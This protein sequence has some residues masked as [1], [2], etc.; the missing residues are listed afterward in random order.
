MDSDI[1]DP[2][3]FAP[4]AFAELDAPYP[5]QSQPSFDYGDPSY[6]STFWPDAE[7]QQ[8]ALPASPVPAP[9]S[10]SSG[11]STFDQQ[12]ALPASPIPAPLPTTS[13]PSTSTSSTVLPTETLYEGYGDPMSCGLPCAKLTDTVNIRGLICGECWYCGAPFSGEDFRAFMNQLAKH[14]KR[15]FKYKKCT[16][17]DR[18]YVFLRFLGFPCLLL[19]VVLSATAP[20]P[21][22]QPT[23]V[24]RSS[25]ALNA[26]LT[27]SGRPTKANLS[28]CTS[29]ASLGTCDQL[30]SLMPR[31]DSHVSLLLL[32]TS[33]PLTRIR[34]LSLGKPVVKLARPKESPKLLE[35]VVVNLRRRST[36][37]GVL[38]ES[39]RCLLLLQVATTRRE[40]FPLLLLLRTFITTPRA[41]SSSSRCA[42][43]LQCRSSRTPCNPPTPSGSNSAGDICLRTS[44]LLILLVGLSSLRTTGSPRIATLLS[45]LL[46]PPRKVSSLRRTFSSQRS[47]RSTLQSQRF[48]MIL[49][50][51]IRR[52]PSLRR[53]F[54]SSPI[55]RSTSEQ[56]PTHTTLL[57]LPTRTFPNSPN[58]PSASTTPFQS[59]SQISTNTLI[60]HLCSPRTSTR[61]V[62]PKVVSRTRRLLW[63]NRMR[64]VLVTERRMGW[65]RASSLEHCLPSFPYVSLYVFSLFFYFAIPPHFPPTPL[66]ATTYISLALSLCSACLASL[67]AI[68]VVLYLSTL[69]F[70]RYPKYIQYEHD[71]SCSVQNAHGREPSCPQVTDSTAATR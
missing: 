33:T 1:A 28:T 49:P 20:S 13:G 64:F 2:Y 10:A 47:S 12:L 34:R 50:L 9:V 65:T 70:C 71:P 39:R 14:I 40:F 21:S 57:L 68:V 42:T 43:L 51:C 4:H 37:T 22:T 62:G 53:T 61:L 52:L 32:S 44:T 16:Q 46:H 55:P 31:S 69:L 15:H 27:L 3:A 8:L 26:T 38:L 66:C 11:P 48:T 18:T 67:V 36:S 30:R 45:F 35:E 19:N 17:C 58:I 56:R 23:T 7:D 24:A 60:L 6:S 63:R 29:Y 54:P 41:C 5:S 25:P 59:Q